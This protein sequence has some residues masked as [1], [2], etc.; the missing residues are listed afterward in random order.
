MLFEI[1]ARLARVFKKSRA[2][3]RKKP[4]E[5]NEWFFG[6]RPPPLRGAGWPCQ[7]PASDSGEPRIDAK[8]DS[9]VEISLT[10]RRKAFR[11]IDKRIESVIR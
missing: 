10:L 4:N 1:L 6:T 2:K 11:G 3:T 9:K 8:K 7:P 5:N